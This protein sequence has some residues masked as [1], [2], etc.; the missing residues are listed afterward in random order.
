MSDIWTFSWHTTQLPG[1]TRGAFDMLQ[2][3]TPRRNVSTHQHSRSCQPAP[4]SHLPSP[5]HRLRDPVDHLTSPP[6][7]FYTTSPTTLFLPSLRTRKNFRLITRKRCCIFLTK[8]TSRH[9]APYPR[10]RCYVQIQ[11][12]GHRRPFFPCSPRVRSTWASEEVNG[13]TV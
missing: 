6:S 9:I 2:R 1:T 13:W 3:P 7:F 4:I 11:G 10:K 5:I 12:Q 8:P